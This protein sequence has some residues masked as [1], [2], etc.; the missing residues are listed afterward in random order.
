MLTLMLM[1]HGKS[2]WDA[3]AATDHDRPLNNR[4]RLSAQTM[5]TVIRERGIV[6]DL[7]VSSTATRARSTAEI[8]RI[9]GGWASRLVLESD[10][11]GAGVG[12]TLLV[13]SRHGGD[14]HR[15][16]LVG[17]QPTWSMTVRHLTGNQV[18]IKTAT[19]AVIE[20]AIDGWLGISAANGTL[21]DLLHPRD[22]MDRNASSDHSSDSETKQRDE[23][24]HN[25]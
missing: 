4:G 1:R 15:L 13:A 8:A 5:G 17:H 16:M 25:P 20:L 24:P 9:S 7:V 23:G 22:F 6:P 10:L 2:D 14:T 11:Y 12:E 19:V 18:D 3:G 21:V